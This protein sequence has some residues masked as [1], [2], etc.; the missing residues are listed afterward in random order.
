MSNGYI[1]KYTWIKPQNRS[2]YYYDHRRY[3][4]GRTHQFLI[5]K[6]IHTYRYSN[7]ILVK[8]KALRKLSFQIVLMK[9]MK[10]SKRK[11]EQS[12]NTVFTLVLCPNFCRISI[13]YTYMYCTFFL[14]FLS[15]VIYTLYIASWIPRD[16]QMHFY[17]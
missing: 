2:A 15:N 5:Y 4:F 11:L 7:S 13:I 14:I 10:C 17:T 6:C 1:Y 16:L 9:K 3:N 8:L 12:I